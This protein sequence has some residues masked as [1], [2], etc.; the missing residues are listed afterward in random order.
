MDIRMGLNI[1]TGK[2]SISSGPQKT[3]KED[4]KKWLGRNPDALLVKL[5]GHPEP[6]APCSVGHLCRI[7]KSDD[8][9]AYFAFVGKHLIGQLPNEAI[10][11]ANSIDYSPDCLISI[12]GKVEDGDVYIYI[13]E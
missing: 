13:A 4:L 9:S 3:R 7:E 1:E 10:E 8:G 2:I 12:I 6:S 11:F 5:I